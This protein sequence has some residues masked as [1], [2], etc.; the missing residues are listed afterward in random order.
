MLERWSRNLGVWDKC[1][2]AQECFTENQKSNTDPINNTRNVANYVRNDLEFERTRWVINV[3]I[4]E[5]LKEIQ[6]PARNVRLGFR[7]TPLLCEAKVDNM[8]LMIAKLKDK[9]SACASV[10]H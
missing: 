6:V 1:K 2:D 3:Q 7:M 8:N 10:L 4:E 5:F 9:R